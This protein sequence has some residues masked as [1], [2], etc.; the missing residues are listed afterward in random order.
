MNLI[1][2]ASDLTLF[3]EALHRDLTQ[4]RE[5]AGDETGRERLDHRAI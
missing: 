1:L 2:H 4:L 3:R 5:G